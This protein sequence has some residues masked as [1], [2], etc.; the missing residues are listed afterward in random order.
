MTGMLWFLFF[1]LLMD[2]HPKDLEHFAETGYKDI[3]DADAT[4]AH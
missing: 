1:P 3:M 4:Q 2:K